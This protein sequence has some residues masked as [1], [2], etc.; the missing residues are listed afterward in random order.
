MFKK[1]LICLLC[2]TYSNISLALNPDQSDSLSFVHEKSGDQVLVTNGMLVEILTKDKQKIVGEFTKGSKSAIHLK[3]KNEVESYPLSDIKKI[4]IYREGSKDP[5]TGTLRFV[6]SASSATSLI[7]GGGAAIG[8]IA[9]ISN[10]KALGFGLIGLSVPLIYYGMKLHFML[11]N[12][13]RDIVKL[14]KGW[15]VSEGSMAPQ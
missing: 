13:D 8:G 4:T 1:V 6:V 15:Q 10:N 9:T 12:A 7:L 14:H 11:K 3:Q 5:I 2:L